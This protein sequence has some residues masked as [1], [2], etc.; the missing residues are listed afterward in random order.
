MGKVIIVSMPK[1][2]PSYAK[3]V[4]RRAL[5]SVVDVPP[6]PAQVEKA[7]AFFGFACAYCGRALDRKN[8]DGHLDHLV[9]ATT[10]GPNHICNRV[11]SCGPCN[12]DEKREKEWETFLAE[13]ISDQDLLRVR[14]T[15]IGEWV[16]LMSADNSAIPKD[17]S[18]LVEREISS[19]IKSFDDAIRKIRD[20]KKA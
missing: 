1:V 5:L 8:R 16:R 10:G 20:A 13:K 11:L 6:T 14:R 4:I 9:S 3:N 2:T 7:W 12:G 19:A 15:K 18:Q 17:L